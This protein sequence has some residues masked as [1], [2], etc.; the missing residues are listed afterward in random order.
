MMCNCNM[1]KGHSKCMQMGG[2]ILL[3]IGLVYVAQS[4]KWVS[5]MLP[6]FWALLLVVFGLFA[7]MESKAVEG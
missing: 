1:H 5:V 4:M 6:N 3:L 7:V 2:V